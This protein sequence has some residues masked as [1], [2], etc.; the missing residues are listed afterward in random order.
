MEQNFWL[1]KNVLETKKQFLDTEDQV[2]D[3]NK[4][5]FLGDHREWK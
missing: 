1:Q 5:F 2:L 4:H 3:T